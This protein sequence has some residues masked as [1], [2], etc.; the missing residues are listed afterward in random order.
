[1]AA[2]SVQARGEGGLLLHNIVTWILQ[3]GKQ[4]PLRI[5]VNLLMS[6]VEHVAENWPQSQIPN[7]DFSAIS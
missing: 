3:G 1:M 4:N 6:N 2:S 7:L 5:H